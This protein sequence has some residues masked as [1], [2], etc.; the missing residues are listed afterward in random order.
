MATLRIKRRRNTTKT[1]DME[2]ETQAK[3]RT[4]VN[5]E[6]AVSV[7]LTPNE[8]METLTIVKVEATV[9]TQEADPVTITTKG[10]KPRQKQR[11]QQ[12]R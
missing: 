8:I 2:T 3:N 11:Q 6:I 10:R 7:T 4:A 1:I 12:T 5:R 9:L